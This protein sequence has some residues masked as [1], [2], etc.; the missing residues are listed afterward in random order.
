MHLR[1][2]TLALAIALIPLATLPAAADTFDV[3][4]R[5]QHERIERGVRN[6]SLTHR[7]AEALREEQGRIYRLIARARGR[8]AA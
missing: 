5:T 2:T 8:I 4:A 6:G 1:S 3:E 7:E